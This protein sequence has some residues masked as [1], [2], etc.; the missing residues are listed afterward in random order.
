MVGAEVPSL[1]HRAASHL[2]AGFL[3][4][5]TS[6]KSLD[7]MR[8]IF[9]RTKGREI[10]GCFV[11]VPPPLPPRPSQLDAVGGQLGADVQPPP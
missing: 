1:S 9:S 10:G 4:R 2:L 3:V 5:P 8:S 11:C 7:E 6:W